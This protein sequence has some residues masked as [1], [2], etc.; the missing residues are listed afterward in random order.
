MMRRALK[1][2]R[3]KVDRARQTARGE[4]GAHQNVI[5]AKAQIAPERVHAVV[6]PGEGFLR[7]DK[8]PEA[9]FQSQGEKRPEGFPLAGAAQDLTFPCLRIV[10]VL[11]GRGDV[12]VAERRQ[13][14]MS[15]KFFFEPAS[16]SREPLELV[17]VFFRVDGLAVGYIRADNPDRAL[18][19]PGGRG[20][21]APLFA[22]AFWHCRW[23]LG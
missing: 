6:P 13:P 8:H 5:D 22:A 2:P 11:V 12:V 4:L 7:L 15:S 9:V 10:D 23:N 17:L 16:E 1:P 20:D 14:R 3:R 21:D 18:A 19:F